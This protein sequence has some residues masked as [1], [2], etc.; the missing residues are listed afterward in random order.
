MSINCTSFCQVNCNRRHHP[1][2]L[3]LIDVKCKTSFDAFR[4]SLRAYQVSG[5]QLTKSIPDPDPTFRHP[6]LHW[7]AVL[8]KV[9]VVKILLKPPFNISPDIKSDLDETALHRVLVFS[10][11]KTN[12]QTIF[13]LI[14]ALHVCLQSVDSEMRTPF[15]IC[16]QKPN[17]WY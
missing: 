6:V 8:G 7:A 10:N 9:E 5:F 17:K 1:I 13:K 12:L 4:H 16:A 15:H 14:D 11:S 2:L 3:F